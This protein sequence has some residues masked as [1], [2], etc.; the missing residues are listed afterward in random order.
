MFI[1]F[2]FEVLSNVITQSSNTND[3]MELKKNL[4]RV[5]KV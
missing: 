4:V 2:T 3:R 1:E 5:G